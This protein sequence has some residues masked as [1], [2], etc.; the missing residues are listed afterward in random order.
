MKTA[1]VMSCV[2]LTAVSYTPTVTTSQEADVIRPTSTANISKE[3]AKERQKTVAVRKEIN[4]EFDRLAKGLAESLANPHLRNY[5]RKQIKESRK[6]EKILRLDKFL[7]GATKEKNIP[8]QAKARGRLK[9]ARDTK[10]KLG[11]KKNLDIFGTDEIDVYFPVP[12]HRGKWNGGDDLLVAFAPVVDESELTEIVAYSVKNGKRVSLDPQKA[13]ETPVVVVTLTEHESLDVPDVP[14]APADEPVPES[15]PP[16]PDGPEPPLEN[17]GKPVGSNSR[18]EMQYLKIFD[19][20]EPWTAGAPEIYVVCSQ[21]DGGGRSVV[22]KRDLARVN[23]T[24]RW[25]WVRDIASWIFERDYW[26]FTAFDVWERDTC[27]SAVA[28]IPVFGPI[29]YLVGNMDD[30]VCKRHIKKSSVPYYGNLYQYMY[31][32]PKGGYM[33]AYK[34]K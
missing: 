20:H 26:D 5:L 18:I 8:E 12:E 7:E 22:G 32:D 3:L 10:K 14:Q 29:G 2:V 34:T 16:V 31:G 15:N 13:P 17:A 11:T 9:A 21:V 27:T 4:A 19:D 1:I 25:Y 30:P 23:D 28:Y 6:R 33:Y 24:H